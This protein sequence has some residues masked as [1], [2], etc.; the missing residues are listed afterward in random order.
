[1]Y[2]TVTLPDGNTARVKNVAETIAAVEKRQAL[3]ARFAEWLWEDP[4][5][6]DRLD[7]ARTTAATTRSCRADSTART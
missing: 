1:M 6:T 7:R 4:E 5:R 3:D 2:D